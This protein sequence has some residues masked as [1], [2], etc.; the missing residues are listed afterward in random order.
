M[1][2]DRKVHYPGPYSFISGRP[3]LVGLRWE[4]SKEEALYIVFAPSPDDALAIANTSMSSEVVSIRIVDV[5]T[6][7][8]I[9]RDPV[10]LTWDKHKKLM[11]NF[12]DEVWGNEEEE[13]GDD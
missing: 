11:D 13:A 9:H 1:D 5:P 4:N 10:V 2:C 8:K 3:Y 7:A 12:F 6:I